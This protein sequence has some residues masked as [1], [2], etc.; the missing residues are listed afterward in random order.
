MGKTH[1]A[2]RLAIAAAEGGR[3]V[4]YGTLAGRIDSLADAKAFNNLSRRL[5][6]LTHPTLMV[7]D[8]IGD[9]PVTREG[10]VLFFQLIN[11]RHEHASTVLTSNNGFEERGTVLG[12]EVMAAAMIDPL[13]HHCHIVNSVATAI[14]CEPTRTCFDL[15]RTTRSGAA[16]V[17]TR[18]NTLANSAG[19]VASH[20]SASCGV[21]CGLQPTGA[22]PLGPVTSIGRPLGVPPVE[23]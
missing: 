10:A 13:L 16:S 2:I 6:V 8:E 20:L 11:A 5:P 7:V 15:A 18:T 9:L 1:L 3:R 14:G 21:S 17:G 19:R 23:P 22:S 12:D 4:C